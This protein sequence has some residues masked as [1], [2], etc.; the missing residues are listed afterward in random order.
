MTLYGWDS[1]GI[2]TSLYVS[3]KTRFKSGFFYHNVLFQ[4]KNYRLEAVHGNSCFS[5]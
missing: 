5:M 4:I 2:D 3:D 1:E